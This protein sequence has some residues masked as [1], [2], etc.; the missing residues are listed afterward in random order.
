M[1][2]NQLYDERA[3]LITKAQALAA[4]AKEHG[5]D[6]N[7]EERAE[8]DKLLADVDALN[9]KIEAEKRT[10][11]DRQADERRFAAL[12]EHVNANANARARQ[13]DPP[14]NRN[15]ANTAQRP[16][17]TREYH[18]WFNAIVRRDFRAAG[19]IEAR[20]GS[21]FS[22]GT[23]AV[24]G[25]LLVPTAVRNEL[26]ATMDEMCGIVGM[27]RRLNIGD[28]KSIGITKV[29][30]RGDD[31]DWTSEVTSVTADTALAIGRRDLTPTMATKKLVVS[32]SLLQRSPDAIP[33]VTQ[34][35]AR[36]FGVTLEKA[37]LTGT[38][39]SQPLGIFVASSN[40]ISTGRDV[41][42]ASTTAFDYTDLIQLKYNLKSYY[43]SRAKLFIHRDFMYKAL[44]LL[45]DQN[46]PIFIPS[47]SPGLAD[48]IAG[49]PVCYSEF[50]PNTYTAAKYIA[51][52]GDPSYVQ[53]ADAMTYS[54]QFADQLLAGTNQ[55]AIFGRMEADAS[56]IL[57]EAFSRLIT[58][59]S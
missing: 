9:T 11:E 54:L 36:L 49:M 14:A 59:A 41:T 50:A 24:G 3:G 27:A 31:A 23:D 35:M 12:N 39:S 30:A 32:M 40:G 37:L 2:L 20:A 51:V 26:I 4:R 38:G 58:A 33:F 53:I 45:D 8:F 7:T 55:V 16:Q 21:P 48:S 47:P 44:T 34:Q 17:D 10:L 25:Y 52:Y 42:A 28:A 46:R 1:D 22:V 5:A 19:Q 29:T 6:L 18:D 13:S 43:Q 56:P 57:E 15:R